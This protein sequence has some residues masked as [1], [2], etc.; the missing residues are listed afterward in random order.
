MIE[1]CIL[2]TQYE[3]WKSHRHPIDWFSG[4]LTVVMSDCKNLLLQSIQ[5]RS[6]DFERSKQFMRNQ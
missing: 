4:N 2:Q 3:Y 5:N 1:F 6:H